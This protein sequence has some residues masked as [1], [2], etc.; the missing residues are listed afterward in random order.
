M[1]SNNLYVMH[2]YL[3]VCLCMFKLYGMMELVIGKLHT[4]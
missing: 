1:N 4:I 2:A 3:P